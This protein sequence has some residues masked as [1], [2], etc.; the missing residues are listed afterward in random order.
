M[1]SWNAPLGGPPLANP[2]PNKPETSPELLLRCG[3]SNGE[4]SVYKGG[5]NAG[6]VAKSGFA[7]A[8]LV[9]TGTVAAV[10]EVISNPGLARNRCAVKLGPGKG[11][12][13]CAATS[14]AAAFSSHGGSG[15][16]PPTSWACRAAV[17][18]IP[19]VALLLSEEAS[20]CWAGPRFRRGGGGHKSGAPGSTILLG[21]RDTSSAM[22]A[23][24]APTNRLG[25]KSSRVTGAL[26]PERKG[27][28]CGGKP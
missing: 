19:K 26:T 8:A 3:G 28:I 24:I 20:N 22:S 14:C 16:S 1:Q 6:G 5:C 25:E 13:C 15:K 23:T 17:P 10:A 11:W 2:C 4:A 27:C 18:S 9:D 12:C 21:G 7:A